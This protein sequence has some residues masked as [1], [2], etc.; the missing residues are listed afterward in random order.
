MHTAQRSDFITPDLWAP[1]S[2]LTRLKSNPVDYS[3]WN[4]MQEKV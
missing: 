3:V 4:I 1:K 2:K